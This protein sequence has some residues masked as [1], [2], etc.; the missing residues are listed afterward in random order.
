MYSYDVTVQITSVVFKI[1]RFTESLLSNIHVHF[2]SH[3]AHFFLELE[4]FHTSVVK[5]ITISILRLIIFPKNLVAYEIMWENL[6]EEDR[7][8]TT[9]KYGLE[10]MQ[11]ACQISKATAQTPRF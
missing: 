4:N 7:S 10:K 1:Q 11:F 2:W 6:V 5:K 9:I 8:Q 3:L